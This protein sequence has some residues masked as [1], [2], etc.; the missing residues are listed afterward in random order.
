[1]IRSTVG[2]YLFAHQPW[3]HLERASL[4]PILATK[5]LTWNKQPDISPAK[6]GLFRSAEDC[7]TGSVAM[8]NRMHIP[9][10]QGKENT[11]YREEKKARWATVNKESMASQR[12]SLLF[13]LLGPATGTDHENSPFWSPNSNELRILFLNFLEYTLRIFMDTELGC[14]EKND[15]AVS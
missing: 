9:I 1:M 4:I 15:N 8:V 2:I 13:F 14:S 11:F 6:M 3:S 10:C 7:N 5:M 12:L